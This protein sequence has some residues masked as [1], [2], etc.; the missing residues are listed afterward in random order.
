[1]AGLVA[2]G[3]GDACDPRR[4][5][6]G[7]GSRCSELLVTAFATTRPVTGNYELE[8]MRIRTDIAYLIVYDLAP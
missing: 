3:V 1:M 5:S 7:I 2:D 4:P 6:R 8:A